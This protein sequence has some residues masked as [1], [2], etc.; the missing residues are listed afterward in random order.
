M[1]YVHRSASKGAVVRLIAI[2]AR[3]RAGPARAAVVTEPG[4]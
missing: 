2:N 4:R 3:G 1:E